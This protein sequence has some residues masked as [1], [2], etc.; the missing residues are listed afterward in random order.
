MENQGRT[1]E[2]EARPV[3]VERDMPD[4]EVT[5]TFEDLL[6]RPLDRRPAS[7]PPRLHADDARRGPEVWRR[8]TFTLHT[9]RRRK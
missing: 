5:V 7:L 8:R 4:A 6:V 3:R 2:R 9:P 1:I